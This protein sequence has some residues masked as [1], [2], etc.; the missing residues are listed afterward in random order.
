LQKR[1]DLQGLFRDR[2]VLALQSDRYRIEAFHGHEPHTAHQALIKPK[3]FRFDSDEMEVNE[4]RFP[5]A[6][7]THTKTSLVF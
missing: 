5:G 3:H 4:M 7:W 1:R 2:L 6:D